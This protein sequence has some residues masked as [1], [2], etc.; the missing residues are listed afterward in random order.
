MKNLLFI[1]MALM[2]ASLI[3]QAVDHFINEDSK[4]N[5]V[6]VY[7]DEKR[8][9][10]YSFLGDTVIGDQTWLKLYSS[11]DTLFVLNLHYHGLIHSSDGI[12]LFQDVN[13]NIRT[14]YNFNLG[15]GDSVFFNIPMMPQKI[16]INK[17]D[18]VQINGLYFKRFTFD[19]PIGINVFD[20]LN[21]VW[22]EGIGSHHGLLFPRSP[23]K[24]ASEWPD[25]LDLTC[26]FTEEIQYWDNP[27]YN[28]CYINIIL[29][30]EELSTNLYKVYP[31]PFKDYIIIENGNLNVDITTIDIYDIQGNIVYSERT[32]NTIHRIVLNNLPVG[33]YYVR[34][35]KDG[36]ITNK[37]IVKL[38]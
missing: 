33:I 1:I 16:A 7:Y 30:K 26:S 20:A 22:I 17:I 4:W 35:N 31:N 11:W 9:T 29:D 24:F 15:V 2:P 32:P 6:S 21:E 8:T 27:S 37:K 23:R 19:E 5:V 28:G 18:S 36:N 25:K 10:Y 34:L 38:N 13:N 14:L 12:V 3:G